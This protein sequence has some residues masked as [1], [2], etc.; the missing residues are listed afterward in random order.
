MKTLSDPRK[1]RKTSRRRRRERE[2]NTFRTK[3]RKAVRARIRERARTSYDKDMRE[4]NS[5]RA[6]KKI[7]LPPAIP[8]SIRHL[9]RSRQVETRKGWR[10]LMGT[11][12]KLFTRRTR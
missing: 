9:V 8:Q 2:L 6:A 1:T 7:V 10:K 3:E 4:L 11:V 5:S 12:A